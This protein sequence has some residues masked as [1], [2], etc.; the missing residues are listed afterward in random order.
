MDTDKITLKIRRFTGKREEWPEWKLKFQA[1]LEGADL[2]DTLLSS[3]P[4]DA[5]TDAAEDRE[6]AAKWRKKDRKIYFQLILYT[7]EA[8]GN[9]VEQFEDVCSGKMAWEALKTKYEH[10]GTVGKVDPHKELMESSMG[11]AEDPDSFFIK[12]EGIQKRLKALGQ[13]ISEEM[14][15]GM[16]LSKLPSNYNTLTTIMEADD[17]LTYESMKN[18]VRAYWKRRIKDV[19]SSNQDEDAVKAMAAD[20]GHSRQR[21]CFGCGSPGHVLPNCPKKDASIP[22]NGWRGRS[23]YRG[24][25]RGGRGGGFSRNTGNRSRPFKI[26]CYTCHKEGHKA[27]ECPTSIH[28]KANQATKQD[29]TMALMAAANPMQGV[30][31][32]TW[33]VDSGCTAHM[34]SSA[35]ELTNIEWG[36][37]QV[38]VAGGKVLES[39]GIGRIHGIVQ[40]NKGTNIDVSFNNVLVVPNLGRNLLSVKKIVSRG[41]KVIFTPNNAVN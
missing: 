21:L 13:V 6:A 3:E 15:Q 18:Q 12:I 1:V 25:K 41:G 5:D 19:D 17:D 8:A 33:I 24:T 34:V 10:Q 36:K 37:G 9:L 31:K 16:I 29:G 38:V 14:V 26:R 28:H 23:S 11:E 7:T 2:L 22:S 32:N 4:V 30:G 40:T 20:G 39:V 35:E 27:N